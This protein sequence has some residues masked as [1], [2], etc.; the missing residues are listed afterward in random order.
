MLSFSLSLAT[1]RDRAADRGA[2]KQL[3]R[4]PYRPPTWRRWKGPS[5][6]QESGLAGL[7]AQNTRRGMPT[8]SE[9]VGRQARCFNIERPGWFPRGRP[10]ARKKPRQLRR[11]FS[12]PASQAPPELV[13]HSAAFPPDPQSSDGDARPRSRPDN[14]PGAFRCH[15]LYFEDHP[16]VVRLSSHLAAGL[17]GATEVLH[18]FPRAVHRAP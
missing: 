14:L 5:D 16:H 18:F 1:I 8:I 9:K 4:A 2:A 10:P 13:I 17:A 12:L 7:Y 11:G 6:G 15:R 3:G